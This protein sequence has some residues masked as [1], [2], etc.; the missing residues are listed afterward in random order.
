MEVV[1]NNEGVLQAVDHTEGLYSK[2]P[3]TDEDPF[4]IQIVVREEAADLPPAPEDLMDRIAYAGE[5]DWLDMQ[6]GAW[7]RC[8]VD[9]RGLRAVLILAPPLAER[10][11]LVSRCVMNTILLN[12][13]TRSGFGML[14]ASCLVRDGRALLLMAPHGSGKSTT[15]LYL[16]LAGYGLMSDSQIYVNLRD[17]RMQLTGFPVGR[18]K[19]RQDML[20]EFPQFSGS[21]T[22][23][24]VRGETKFLVD[25]RRGHPDMIFD[26]ALEPEFIELCL[27]ARS[28]APHT[29]RSSPTED[30]VL[31]AVM[32]NSLHYDAAPVWEANLRTL[33]ALLKRA[34]AH[35]LSIGTESE[36][37]LR[38]VDELWAET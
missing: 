23:E 14:H 13:L 35:R 33:D 22:P 34:R 11:D 27:L 30:E 37:I 1:S 31:R 6:L 24:R 19:L 2:A 29:E 4:S 18:I 3:P 9:L 16:M 5:A 17:G 20:S 10:P 32:E 25:L 36:G 12:L 15:A 38:A 21:I 8:H 7:G 26:R 28:G